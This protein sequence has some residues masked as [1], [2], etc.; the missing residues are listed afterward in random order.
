MKK[1]GIDRRQFL[2]AAGAAA[3]AAPFYRLLGPQT[4]R[5]QDEGPAKR[6]IFMMTSNGFQQDGIEVTGTG[7]SFT[8]GPSSCA[9]AVWGPS[10]R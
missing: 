4:A 8:L 9:R 10:R 7:T 5:A 1:P 3:L 2:R 6:F